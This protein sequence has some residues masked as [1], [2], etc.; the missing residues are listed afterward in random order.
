MH[1]R[2]TMGFE[3]SGQ[4]S[5]TI[6]LGRN[7]VFSL[8]SEELLESCPDQFKCFSC[9]E[10]KPNAKLGGKTGGEWL[11]KRCFPYVDLQT[12]DGIRKFDSR[13][14]THLAK[15]GKSS[16]K[17]PI[18]RED[19]LNIDGEFYDAFTGQLVKLSEKKAQD[20]EDFR[21][22]YRIWLIAK[23]MG[24]PGFT[25]PKDDKLS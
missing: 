14:V 24:F 8:P 6:T 25:S 15:A 16:Q 23:G 12:V 5:A 18:T 7:P 1:P 2:I 11:C 22:A 4:S 13:L 17:P 20:I 9:L 10:F 3:A 19:W 21:K